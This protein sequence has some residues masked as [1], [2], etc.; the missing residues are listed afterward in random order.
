MT[1]SEPEPAG[2][3]LERAILGQSPE[4]NAPEVADRTGVTID[5][6]R[7]LWRALGFPEH[8]LA[9]A[10]TD[11]DVEALSTLLGVVRRGVIDF[12]MAVNLTRAVGQTMS[13]LADW[14]V[15]TLLARVEELAET[16]TVA[17]APSRRW[18]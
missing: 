18:G 17:G 13:R 2:V 12:D 3:D 4:L 5:E 14:E 15:A 7:R 10:F 16:D 8:G 1:A 11:A 9:T 6:A